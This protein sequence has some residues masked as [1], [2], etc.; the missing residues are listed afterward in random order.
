MIKRLLGITIVLFANFILLA[1][2]VI[3]HHHHPHQVCLV[4]SHCNSGESTAHSHESEMPVHEHDST[5]G[6]EPCV[7]KQIIAVPPNQFRINAGEDGSLDFC[8][9]G[10]PI[11]F[12][13]NDEPNCNYIKSGQLIIFP[14]IPYLNLPSY[15]ISNCGLRAPPM[16]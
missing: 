3:P 5:N 4:T 12:A 13:D 6:D 7:L 1:H 9:P 15:Y 16:A 14:S 8:D 10:F 11:E 2:N